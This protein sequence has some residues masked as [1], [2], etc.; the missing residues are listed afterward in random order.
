MV[1]LIGLVFA[2]GIGIAA[3]TLASE[4]IGLTSEPLES[5]DA[6]APAG[7]THPVRRARPPERK[8]RVRRAPSE[9]PPAAAPQPLPPAV[10]TQEASPAAGDDSGHVQAER[11]RESEPDGDSD[12]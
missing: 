6:L 9:Q 3:S 5:G 1:A 8:P 7:V 11:E 4:R 12:D 10:G 2:V